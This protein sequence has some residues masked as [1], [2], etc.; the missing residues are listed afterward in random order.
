MPGASEPGEEK[1]KKVIKQLLPV[2][3]LCKNVVEAKDKENV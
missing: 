1:D 2:I 3:M